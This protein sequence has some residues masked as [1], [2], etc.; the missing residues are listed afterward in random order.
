MYFFLMW[1]STLN[2]QSIHKKF[3]FK[4][5]FLLSVILG[6]KP[7]NSLLSGNFYFAKMLLLY[8]IFCIL[9]I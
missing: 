4:L 6:V 8:E 1:T 3:N 2:F 5:C 7:V 9:V